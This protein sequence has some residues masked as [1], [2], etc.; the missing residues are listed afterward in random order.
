M[1]AFSRCFV[2]KTWYELEL[3]NE[4]EKMLSELGV[5]MS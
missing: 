2:A 4:E 1:K 3:A 5:F